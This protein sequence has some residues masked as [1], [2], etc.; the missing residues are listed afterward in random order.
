[1]F[2]VL[3]ESYLR[4]DIDIF[5]SNLFVI[6]MVIKS[7]LN[8]DKMGGLE[9][10]CLYVISTHLGTYYTGITNSLVRRWH[11]HVS[12]QSRYLRFAGAKEV[13]YV[14]YF[15]N[16]RLAAKKER[17]IKNIGAG[18]YLLRLKHRL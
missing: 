5:N 3:F 15:D 9:L 6:A 14:E 13:V 18:N 7:G 12:G 11:E 10:I 4:V 2:Q 8:G 16:R 17:K 1:M